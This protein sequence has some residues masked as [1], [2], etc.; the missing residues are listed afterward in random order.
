[1]PNCLSYPLFLSIRSLVVNAHKILKI[2]HVDFFCRR[3]FTMLF[4]SWRIWEILS[5]SWHRLQ[6]LLSVI[7]FICPFG[8]ASDRTVLSFRFTSQ[9]HLCSLQSVLCEGIFELVT[10]YDLEKSANHPSEFH[11]WLLGLLGRI[12]RSRIAPFTPVVHESTRFSNNFLQSFFSHFSELH[13]SRQDR[14]DRNI[15]TDA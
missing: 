2:S 7:S 5:G 13:N 6:H 10:E 12:I 14:L 8:I 1:M 3:E 4:K 9:C 11:L 15:L